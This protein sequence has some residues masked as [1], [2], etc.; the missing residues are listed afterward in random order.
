MKKVTNELMDWLW[1]FADLLK[2]L[3]VIGL[4]VGVLFKND[5][6]GMVSRLSDLMTQIGSDGVVGLIA[7]V[8]LLSW[9]KKK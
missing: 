7:L 3:L 2:V 1:S 8:V 5:E 9:Y 6:F 4:L